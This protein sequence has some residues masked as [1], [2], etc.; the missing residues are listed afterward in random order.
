[1]WTLLSGHLI[2]YIFK[3]LIYKLFKDELSNKNMSL[4]QIT[5]GWL[6]QEHFRQDFN[7]TGGKHF[8]LKRDFRCRFIIQSIKIIINIIFWIHTITTLEL[9]TWLIFLLAL[10]YL[11]FVKMITRIKTEY[12]YTESFTFIIVLFLTTQGCNLY[13]LFDVF[14]ITKP[15]VIFILKIYTM[16]VTLIFNYLIYFFTIYISKTLS[17]IFRLYINKISFI[18]FFLLLTSFFFINTISR[19]NLLNENIFHELALRIFC[20]KYFL[21]VIN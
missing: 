11:V 21:K 5:F 4:A 10:F 19:E 1:V 12:I 6:F 14:F 20:F 16:I 8:L 2:S 15:F 9:G 3:Y 17:L 7:T 13:K 18:L